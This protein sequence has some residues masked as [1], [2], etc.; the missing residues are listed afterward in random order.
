MFI[1]TPTRHHCDVTF[2]FDV[3]R[4][5]VTFQTFF[6]DV[7]RRHYSFVC[8]ENNTIFT[9]RLEN[10][11]PF[12]QNKRPFML[13][14]IGTKTAVVPAIYHYSN[15]FA[16]SAFVATDRHH[17]WKAKNSLSFLMQHEK[18]LLEMFV[19]SCWINKRNFT[20]HQ[21]FIRFCYGADCTNITFLANI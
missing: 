15:T 18:W 21:H 16:V 12:V 11:R 5:H 9:Q 13:R 3:I 4:R 19:R 10:K 8:V 17:H 6:S 14:T 7:I 2:S 20:P 1:Y